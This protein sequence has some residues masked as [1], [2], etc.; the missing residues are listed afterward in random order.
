ME[1]N[2]ALLNTVLSYHVIPGV[3]A[4]TTDLKDG[5]VLPTWD[6]NLTLTVSESGSNVQFIPDSEDSPPATVVVPNIKAGSSEV[7]IINQ[8]LIP[9]YLA[10]AISNTTSLS[11]SPLSSG[12]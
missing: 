7:H 6:G 1:S 4:T 2:K 10:S 12:K 9:A 3:A 5:E 8:V 11:P